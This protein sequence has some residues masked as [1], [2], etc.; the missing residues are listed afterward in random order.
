MRLG[1]L[2]RSGATFWITLLTCEVCL[3]RSE[4]EFGWRLSEKTV[5]ACELLCDVHV[6]PFGRLKANGSKKNLNF[7]FL[8]L[9]PWQRGK[10]ECPGIKTPYW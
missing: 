1:N 3:Q 7:V 4:N 5:T 2:K 9:D 10:G 6:F 8:V